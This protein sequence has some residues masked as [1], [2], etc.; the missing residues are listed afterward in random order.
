MEKINASKKK[1]GFIIKSDLFEAA[2][3]IAIDNPNFVENH[4]YT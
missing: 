4:D 3:A 1:P 2:R